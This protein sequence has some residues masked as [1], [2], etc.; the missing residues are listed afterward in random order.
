MVKVV[1]LAGT[2]THTG[3]HR[4]TAM[5]LGDVVDELHDEHCLADAGATEEADLAATGI[6]G[7][8]VHDLDTGHEDFLLGR[9]VDE[10]RRRAMDRQGLL[11]AHLT[12][13]IHGLAHDVEN[14]PE[15]LGPDRHADRAARIHGLLAAHEA[16]R[17]VHGDGP[18]RR[19]SQVLGDFEHEAPAA[20]ILSLI[21]I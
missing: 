5:R 10:L 21:H 17:R 6:G 19:F 1:A 20:H 16:V 14:P 8:Q 2:L 13:L 11:R 9:L 12:P 4:I 18:H 15:R 7:Q 3:K